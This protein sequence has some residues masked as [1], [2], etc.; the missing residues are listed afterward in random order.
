M[1]SG[2]RQLNSWQATS[3]QLCRLFSL[4]TSSHSR[5]A[6]EKALD[7]Y[8]SA[9]YKPNGE[10]RLLL[11]APLM[12]RSLRANCASCTSIICKRAFAARH[13]PG[14][15]LREEGRWGYC[16][17][18]MHLQLSVQLKELL[19]RFEFPT[20][21]PP[22]LASSTEVSPIP[23]SHASH[24]IRNGAVFSEYT[25]RISSGVESGAKVDGKVQARFCQRFPF[26][27]LNARSLS[28]RF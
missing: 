14:R 5:V 24:R 6:L 9:S 27:P 1:R 17:Y 8:I 11:C 21:S 13:N 25:A 22:P 19:A 20:C 15:R 28:D 26:P 7:G 23:R 3:R 16:T 2:W 12:A 4:S 18:R 10:V